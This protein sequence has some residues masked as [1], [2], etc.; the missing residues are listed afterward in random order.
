MGSCKI[1]YPLTTDKLAETI[2][3]L[4]NPAEQ[5]FVQ[6]I[7]EHQGIIHKVASLYCDQG[8]ER[9]DLFQEIVLQLWRAYPNYK[10]EAKLTTWMYRIALN[11]AISG[12][13]KKKRSPEL[14][15]ITDHLLQLPAQAPDSEREEQRQFLYRA[16][17]QLSEVEKALVMLQLEDHSYDEIAEIIGI[18]PN[19]VGVK[20]NR[21]KAKLRNILLP[22]FSDSSSQ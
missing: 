11:T 21:I 17:E 2:H 5:T 4:V 16:I 9:R 3:T 1:S 20:F 18:T 12:F 7:S 15:P 10:G 14:Q 19:Y 8:E 6:L 22:Q 13:R